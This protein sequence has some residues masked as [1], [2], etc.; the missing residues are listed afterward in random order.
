MYWGYGFWDYSYILV[1][2]GAVLS[3]IAS[4]RVRITYNKYAQVRSAGGM[5]GAEVARRIL[6]SQGVHDVRIEHVSGNL[7][8]HFDPREMVVRLSDTVYNS[9]S[10]AAAGVAAHECGHVMQEEENYAPLKFRENLVPVANFGSS[11]SWPLILIGLLIRSDAGWYIAI[12]GVILFSLAVLFQL[13]TLPVEFDASHRALG[14]LEDTGILGH[15]ELRD[16]RKVLHAAAMTYVA[17]AAAAI[18]QLLRV[19]LI[20]NSGRRRD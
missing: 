14:I 3:L 6:E 19:M 2:I 7:T 15:E 10:V 8:D 16:T 1:L 11:I 20:A 18:L 5:T 9:T 4:A 12:A 13:V 17:A